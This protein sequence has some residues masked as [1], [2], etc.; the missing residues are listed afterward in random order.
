MAADRFGRMVAAL[1]GSV[2]VLALLTGCTVDRESDVDADAATLP[3]TGTTTPTVT[4]APIEVTL[5][6]TLAADFQLWKADIDGRAGMALMPVGGTRPVVFGDWTSGPAWSTIKVPLVIAAQ[7]ADATV[8]A[9]SMNAAVTASDNTAADALWQGLGGGKQAAQA[10]EEVLREVGDSTTAVPATRPRAEHSAFGQSEWSLAEQIR[11]A[12]QLPCLPGSQTVLELMGQI[13][14]NHQWGLGTVT[15]AHFKGGW[16]PDTSGNYLVRQF[17]II[18]G[19]GGRIAVA[20]AAEP[21]SGT[22]ADGMTALNG[23]AELISQHLD[24]L[25]GGSCPS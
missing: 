23:M 24:E 7:R 5:P 3:V 6:G 15:G 16:G 10:I 9:Y 20:M 12:A 19:P 18:D 1:G 14:P 22:F 17:G 13:I 4:G 25:A 2:L 11:F 8:S 21:E